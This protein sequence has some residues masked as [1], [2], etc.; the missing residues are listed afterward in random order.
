MSNTNDLR[1][2]QRVRS[3][4]DFDHR[5]HEGVVKDVKYVP[6]RNGGT[7]AIVQVLVDKIDGRKVPPDIHE[8]AGA[9]WRPVY[10]N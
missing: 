4:N 7:A 1:V 8:G 10:T 5:V 6:T 9:F 3:T 2:D